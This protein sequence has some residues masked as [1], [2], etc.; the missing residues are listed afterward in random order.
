MEVSHEDVLVVST[1]MELSYRRLHYNHINTTPIEIQELT[2]TKFYIGV[3]F[4]DLSV[5]Q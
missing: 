4:V 1:V 2:L 3:H 5:I